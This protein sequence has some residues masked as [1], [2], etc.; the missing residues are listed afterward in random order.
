MAWR[1][2][3]CLWLDLMTQAP[4]HLDRQ[5]IFL[6]GARCK[7]NF[8][9]QQNGHWS[10]MGKLLRFGF[11]MNFR[12]R[13]PQKG[14]TATCTIC[15]SIQMSAR[16]FAIVDASHS[17]GTTTCTACIISTTRRPGALEWSACVEDLLA[18]T[19]EWSWR[20]VGV[21][22]DCRGLLQSLWLANVW[23]PSCQSR[24]WAA[25][26]KGMKFDRSCQTRSWHT[27]LSEYTETQFPKNPQPFGGSHP[28]NSLLL[29]LVAHWGS[30]GDEVGCASA[31]ASLQCGSGSGAT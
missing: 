18:Q 1:G 14:G 30:L 25:A 21:P 6:S 3:G 9:M 12:T 23:Y 4:V 26:P 27:M 24:V 20:F 11:V 2:V 28:D 19:L 13:S 10:S 17:R 16:A 31:G 15:A 22:S 7:L 8:S 5:T 29:S